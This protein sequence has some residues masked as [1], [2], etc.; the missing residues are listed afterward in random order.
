MRF[1]YTYLTWFCVF[2]PMFAFGQ[3]ATS[4]NLCPELNKGYGQY[5]YA[6]FAAAKNELNFVKNEALSEACRAEKYM[7]LGALEVIAYLNK[8]AE[9]LD[10][11][12][13]FFKEAI[14]ID[15]FRVMPK[16]VFPPLLMRSRFEMNRYKL[17]KSDLQIA[18]ST[19]AP[20]DTLAAMNAARNAVEGL[21]QKYFS[22]EHFQTIAATPELSNAIFSPQHSTK[23]RIEHRVT[24]DRGVLVEAA[25]LIDR[26]RVLRT[27]NAEGVLFDIEK[28][29]VRLDLKEII[30]G[31]VSITQ[32]ASAKIKQ[33]LQSAGFVVI[34]ETLPNTEAHIL[35]RGNVDASTLRLDMGM[36]YGGIAISD[37]TM[38]W[39]DGSNYEFGTSTE[40]IDGKAKQG[41]R[42]AAFGALEA[43][44]DKL[45]A[46]IRDTCIQKWNDRMLNGAI[47]LVEVEGGG[48]SYD[49]FR[50]VLTQISTFALND[51]LD[52]PRYNQN[53]RTQIYLQYRPKD[54]DLANIVRREGFYN[55][56]KPYS[57][58]ITEVAFNHVVIS[59]KSN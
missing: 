6:E 47:H 56:S 52:N 25:H 32:F 7:L 1:R 36:G 9:N 8:R 57:V 13:A 58:N 48:L 55:L 51:P 29:Y 12:D 45:A 17:T 31:D 10:E 43:I 24:S 4:N 16:S 59:L 22:E 40:K 23:W 21:I 44:S 5:A 54:G 49:D 27:M 39:A 35:I 41:R 20:N 28:P 2:A 37:L 30:D 50:K 19:V 11:A 33:A 38:R 46:H 14:T 34:D 15:P 3:E 42:E 53:G 18:K 26:N